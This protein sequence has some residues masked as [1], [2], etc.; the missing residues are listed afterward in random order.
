AEIVEAQLDRLF[1]VAVVNVRVAGAEERHQR[2]G[3]RAGGRTV[4]PLVAA[5]SATCTSVIEMPTAVLA[6]M[7]L[8]PAQTSFDRIFTLRRAASFLDER[9]SSTRSAASQ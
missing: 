8:Q 5:K 6:L 4:R 3:G 7:G 9:G 2:Q 1:V